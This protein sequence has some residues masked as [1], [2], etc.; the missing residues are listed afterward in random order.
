[1]AN[2]DDDFYEQEEY[3]DLNELEDFEEFEDDRE[4]EDI[5]PQYSFSQQCWID[6]E[7]AARERLQRGEIDQEQYDELRHGA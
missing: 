7:E 5:T 4:D 3:D 2:L 6:R 1:M